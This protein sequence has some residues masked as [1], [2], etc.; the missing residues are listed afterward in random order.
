MNAAAA[1]APRVP[2]RVLPVIVLAQLCGASLW[3]A[4]NAIVPALEQRWSLSGPQAGLLLGGV[5]AGFIVGTL[6]YAL[7]LVADRFRARRVFL[8]SAVLGALANAGIPALSGSYEAMLVSRW[9]VGFFLAGIYPVGMRIATDWYRHGLGAA[10]GLLVGALV[11]AT[12]LPHAV[13]AAGI[14]LPPET[15]LNWLSVLAICGGLAMVVFVPDPPGREAAHRAGS[16]AGLDVRALTV[17][18]RDPRVRASAFGYFGHMWELYAMLAFTPL[19]IA[20][21]LHTGITAGVSMLSFVVI[22]AGSVGCVV[23]GLVARRAG[24]ARVAV[25]QLALSG[26]CCLL[27]PWMMA[28]PWWLFAIWMLL[29][30]TVV[31]GDSPQ[32][33]TLTA[34]NAPPAVVGSVL[35]LVNCIGF[36]ISVTTIQGVAWWLERGT[37]EQVLPWLAVGPLVGL[38]AMRPLLRRP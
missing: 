5:N 9:L 31:S 19:I 27:V 6:V 17:I 18:W 12:A 16:R 8:A 11:F 26:I 13:R 10:L 33:S 25:V 2:R 22:A 15:V 29:W 28:A 7:F 35:T 14:G 1:S 4:G 38:W 32:F 3:F 36:A 34:L 24:S 20:T 30:G 21:Y 37:L 23:G